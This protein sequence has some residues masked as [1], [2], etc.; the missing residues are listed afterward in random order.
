MVVSIAKSTLV[1]MLYDIEKE[2]M[3]KYQLWN[4]KILKLY[5]DELKSKS[6]DELLKLWRE[7]R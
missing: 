5:L 6:Y 1:Y 7:K 4:N 2:F 3:L